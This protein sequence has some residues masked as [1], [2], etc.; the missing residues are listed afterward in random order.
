[1][2]LIPIFFPQITSFHLT[3]MRVVSTSAQTDEHQLVSES[4]KPEIRDLR[5]QSQTAWRHQQPQL[6][7]S[8]AETMKKQH[9]ARGY[10]RDVKDAI[11]ALVGE[12]ERAPFSLDELDAVQI[13]DK[14]KHI[15]NLHDFASKKQKESADELSKLK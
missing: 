13:I 10:G 15:Q 12:I 7:D 6:S 1:M 8:L 3:R 11:K 2:V 5:P 4:Q 14:L 9:Q